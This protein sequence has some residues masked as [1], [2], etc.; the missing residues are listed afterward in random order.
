MSTLVVDAS[1]A[2]ELLLHTPTAERIRPQI[3]PTTRLIAPE[4][5]DAEVLSVI[6]ALER[7]GQIQTPRANTAVTDLA[8][9]AITRIGH[10]RL[11]GTAWT[12]RHNLSI[13]DALYVA[14]AKELSAPLMTLDRRLA[15][16]PSLGI[17]L[18]LADH[19]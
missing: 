17:A 3:S 5:L 2:V 13:Y 10:R 16:T 12:L 4:L 19:A 11:I 7:A 1:I 18:H 8:Q 15:A 9:A 14:L 6:K